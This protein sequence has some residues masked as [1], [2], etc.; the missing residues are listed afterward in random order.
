MVATV[1]EWSAS[2]YGATEDLVAKS[3]ISHQIW[4]W[5]MELVIK[6]ENGICNKSP[7]LEIVIS[8]DPDQDNGTKLR[9]YCIVI[10]P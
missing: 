5:Y 3:G 7:N 1:G 9:N 10:G 2:R 4:K 8:D 6:S